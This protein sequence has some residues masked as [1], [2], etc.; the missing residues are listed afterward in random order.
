MDDTLISSGHT[1]DIPRLRCAII[2]ASELGDLCPWPEEMLI[3]EDYIRQDL[4]HQVGPISNAIQSQAWIL[5]YKE[6][7]KNIGREINPNIVSALGVTAAQWLQR[8]YHMYEGLSEIIAGLNY[9]K[10]VGTLGND[11]IQKF[12]YD[13]ANIAQCIPKLHV[14]S[15]KTKDDFQ[16]ILDAEGWLASE[17]VMVGDNPKLDI[18]PCVELGMDAFH[19]VHPHAIPF[20]TDK[21]KYPDRTVFFISKAHE[22]A[23][24]L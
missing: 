20:Q 10:V 5:Y 13:S 7:C 16:A 15:N 24:Y 22:I 19:V 6:L 12:K 18:Q 2:V 8:E 11:D 14:M 21:R 3:R 23:N 17:T 9:N 4:M 1:F